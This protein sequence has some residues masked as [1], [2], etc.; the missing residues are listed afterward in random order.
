MLP[1][2]F[3]TMHNDSKHII[4]SAIQIRIIAQIHKSEKRPEGPYT[5]F[6]KTQ[7]GPETKSKNRETKGP[8]NSVH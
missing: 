8:T 6:K 3:D 5:K 2:I 7:D 1:R 4:H